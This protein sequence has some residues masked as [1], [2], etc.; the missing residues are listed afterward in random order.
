[1]KTDKPIYGDRDGQVYY[2]L[3]KISEERR[4]GYSW[5]SDYGI[6]AVLRDYR[7]LDGLGWV[8]YQGRSAQITPLASLRPKVQDLLASLD[9]QGR[10]VREG[11]IHV[12]DYVR[13]VRLLCDFLALSR[14]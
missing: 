10:W 8:D 4:T 11:R 3:A 14:Y 1:L 9:D 7:L 5:Q 2:D 12:E 6:S 13:N